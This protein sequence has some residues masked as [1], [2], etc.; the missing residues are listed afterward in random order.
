M[1]EINRNGV[2]AAITILSELASAGAPIPARELAQKL[3]IPR[4][5]FYRVARCLADYGAIWLADGHVGAGEM[6]RELA[7]TQARTNGAA[8][9]QV[10]SRR[11]R[12]QNTALPAPSDPIVLSPPPPRR[13][14]RRFHLA[15]SNASIDNA[16][17]VAL[18]H[19][20]EHAAA[21]YGENIG[22]LSIR[23]AEG[24][25]EHQSA[26]IH[27]LLDEGVDGLVVS[28]ADPA[29]IADA[30]E[31]AEREAVP[32]VLVDRATVP[33]VPHH[34][35]VWAD[36]DAI[37]RLPALWLCEK[38]G[39]EGAILML[40]GV[41]GAVPARRRVAA[42]QDVFAQFPG[43]EV[44]ELSWTD[45]RPDAGRRVAADAIARYGQ[46]INGVWCDSGL[47]GA[48]SM[49]AFIASGMAPGTIPPHTGGDLNLAYKLAIRHQIALAAVD[50]PPAM[51]ATAVEVLRLALL[52]NWIP[53]TIHVRSEVILTRGQATPSVK[54]TLLAE[55]HVRWDLP[56]ELV[57]ASGLGPAYN[58]RSFRIHYP[59]NRYNRSAAQ[60]SEEAGS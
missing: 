40:G 49:Q 10:R 24:S 8:E 27:S 12:V 7:L 6:A 34:A 14:A 13:P 48:G 51:G 5:S 37:G 11:P 58:P 41:E 56:D 17:R 52:G 3:G 46:R 28:A 44:L 1:G 32:V 55:D 19:A 2:D 4:S 25:A 39:G 22:K 50:Y 38:L 21:S 16:W 60:P 26:D 42:A 23:H 30:L 54:A 29:L 35:L 53:Q 18:V 59:G 15:F 9:P 36:N 31:R 20:V 33:S 45:W 47:Q 43:I 57:L